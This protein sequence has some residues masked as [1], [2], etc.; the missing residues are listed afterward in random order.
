M[1]ELKIS[2]VL[3][4][5]IDHSRQKVIIP[6]ERLAAGKE[7]E[8]TLTSS[9]VLETIKA[10]VLGPRIQKSQIIG[11]FTIVMELEYNQIVSGMLFILNALKVATTQNLAAIETKMV[12]IIVLLRIQ[13]LEVLLEPRSIGQDGLPIME[14][15]H[16][17]IVR[18]GGR[19]VQLDRGVEKMTIYAA[20]LLAFPILMKDC[21]G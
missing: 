20:I 21:Q 17:V 18:R 2:V 11:C 1:K 5:T 13:T 16:E 12:G 10:H 15:S 3:L 14:K 6:V 4:F 9:R 8:D 19:E 7:M